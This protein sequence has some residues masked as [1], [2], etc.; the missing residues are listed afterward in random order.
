MCK[1][2]PEKPC[3]LVEYIYKKIHENNLWPYVLE[4]FTA[5]VFVKYKMNPY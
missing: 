2:L 1:F 3:L 4:I 5:E